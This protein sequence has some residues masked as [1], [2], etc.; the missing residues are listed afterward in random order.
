[1]QKKQL[2]YLRDLGLLEFLGSG[3]YKKLWR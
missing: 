3:N 2:Q 1:Y